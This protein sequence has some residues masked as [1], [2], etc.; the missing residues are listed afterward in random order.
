LIRYDHEIMYF[1]TLGKD[2]WE[3][4]LDQVEFMGDMFLNKTSKALINPGYPFIAAPFDEFATFKKDI[5]SI[6]K[7]GEFYCS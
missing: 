7:E 2:T 4:T 6:F 3:V 5:E 1:N